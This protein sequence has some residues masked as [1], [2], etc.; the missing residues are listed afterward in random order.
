MNLRDE[1]TKV[2]KQNGQL[3]PKILVEAARPASH[4]LHAIV[5]DVSP[6]LAAE[7]YYLERAHEVIQSVR[8]TYR[9]PK[10]S[11]RYDVRAFHAVPSGE[12]RAFA[13]VPNEEVVSDPVLKA[14]VLR[15]MERDW[16]NLHA[17]YGA[18]KEFLE[19][20]TGDLKK[21]A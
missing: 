16:R 19:L 4:P 7:R 6:K 21:T 13:Y 5:Y 3:T 18:F 14:L 17:R 9:D 20:V 10:N 2:Y 1:L 8:I 11:K 15:E 12:D